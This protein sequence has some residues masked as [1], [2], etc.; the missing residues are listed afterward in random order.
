MRL[1]P[2]N[3]LEPGMRL[4]HDV[5]TG[6]PGTAPLLR[7]GVELDSRYSN[8]L[9]Q[10]GIHAIWV[11]DD[12]GEG[13]EPVR[14]LSEE[15]RREALAVTGAALAEART[16]LADGQSLSD[17]AL[18]DLERIA[19][20]IAND[21]VACPDAALA[22]SDL[23]AADAYTYRH[24]V[25]VAVGG[26]LLARTLFRERGWTDYR[27]NR[28]FD[29]VDERLALLGFGLLVHDIGKLVVPLEV[30]NKRGKLTEEEWLLMRSHPEAGVALLP[31]RRV[32]PLVH[33]VVG[34]HHE[35]WDG[36]GY[37]K[38]LAGTQIHQYA[39]IAAVADVYDAI[40]SERPYR[41]AMPP[42][43]GVR[44]I[45][46]DAHTFDPEVVEV[47][48]E[49]VLPYPPGSPVTLPDG[50]EGVVVSVERGFPE[51]PLVRVAGPGGFEELEVELPLAEAA[52][53]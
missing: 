44:T 21:I 15:T 43:L 53:A 31:S 3:R 22:L 28:R 29:R 49:V 1:V 6:R 10:S 5:T 9:L 32:S 36:T 39:R 13:I 2:I 35:R 24:S 14:P 47:F 20:L 19:Q 17:R 7:A 52:P 25:G 48:R 4:G 38:G 18:D 16:A 37:P 42:A 41:A 12:L 30:L 23:A 50:R 46:K 8:A 40:T 33:A 27:G 26:M 51:R 11:E 34:S 45:L